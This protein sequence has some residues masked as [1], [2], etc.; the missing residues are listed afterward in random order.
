MSAYTASPLGGFGGN[1][2]AAYEGD[3]EQ[4]C[5]K[6]NTQPV[7]RLAVEEG[8]TYLIRVSGTG[9]GNLGGTQVFLATHIE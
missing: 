6:S 9:T 1:V 2:I 8:K 7:I 3:T 5:E 4:A